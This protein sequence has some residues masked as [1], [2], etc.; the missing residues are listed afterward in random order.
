MPTY[1]YKAIDQA[2]APTTG[3]L[4]AESEM[5]LIEALEKRGC[6]LVESSC[7]GASFTARKVYRGSVRP[8]E[9]I[10]FTYN[11]ILILNS[12]IPI[13]E[14]LLEMAEEF[15]NPGFKRVLVDLGNRINSGSTLTDAMATYPK[16]FNTTYTS[17]VSAGEASGSLEEVLEKLCKFL[18]W[19][20][21]NKGQII[22]AAIYPAILCLAVVG[23]IVLL[24]TFL[25]PRI[26]G[27]FEKSTVELPKPTLILL[28]LSDILVNQWPI[29]LGGLGAVV[30]TFIVMSRFDQGRYIIDSMKLRIPFFGTLM[31]QVAAAN[32]CQSLATMTHAGLALPKALHIVSK[33]LNNKVLERA[34]LSTQV[35]VEEGM[36]MS[37]AIKEV[38]VFQ[39]LVVRLVSIGEETG[40][41]ESA[42]AHVTAYYDRVVPQAVKRFMAM[43]EPCIIL[44]AG[45]TV[46]F[47][48][49]CTLLPIF[50]LLKAVKG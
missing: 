39:P 31:R 41:L 4:V 35:R 2:G 44:F 46:G 48:I 32:F 14:G 43:V 29:I 49:L 37:E 26:A 33:V 19:R 23:L 22:Q 13:R 27:I 42:L 28:Q 40:N 9:L 36:S 50:R 1:T 24:L 18:E 30:T 20:E 7:K 45:A 38:G 6:F 11:L 25:L 21:E 17:I 34:V 47:I 3:K 16:I 15:E 5:E 12:G 8:R 10:D